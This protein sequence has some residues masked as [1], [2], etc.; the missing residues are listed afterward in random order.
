M[1]Y[2]KRSPTLPQKQ[3]QKLAFFLRALIVNCPSAGRH[4]LCPSSG[5]L[6]GCFHPAKGHVPSPLL[7]LCLQ[8]LHLAMLGGLHVCYIHEVLLAADAPQPSHPL[9]QPFTHVVPRSQLALTPMLPRSSINSYWDMGRDIS[10]WFHLQ[11]P[12]SRRKMN[13]QH[14]WL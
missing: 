4:G 11:V 5:K 10:S 3:R 12:Q 8:H 7:L 1:R 13:Q 14:T 2:L 6:A 9:W